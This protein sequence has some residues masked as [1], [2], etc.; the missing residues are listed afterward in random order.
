MATPLVV[1]V[2]P[3]GSGK[4]ALALQ[5]ATKFNGEIISAD[6]RTIYEGMDIGTAKPSKYDQAKV[7]H[8]L[9]S[10]LSPNEPFTAAE[11]QR[12]ASK[13]IDEITGR[14]K[15]PIIVGGTG[16]YIDGV[17]FDFAFLPPVPQAEREEL[18]RLSVKELQDKLT[19]EGIA[20]PDNKQNPRHLIR[21]LETNGA[22]P[23]KKNLR[24]NTLMLGIDISKEALLRRIEIRV[25]QMVK[26]GLKE[27]VY[28]LAEQYGWDAPGLSGVGYKEWHEFSSTNEVKAAIV[29]NTM[30]YAKRQ[31]TW[32][33][34]N[35]NINWV[36]NSAEA[37]KLVQ[38]FLQ[39]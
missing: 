8:Y 33:K 35:L 13:K 6:S 24:S 14:G 2:G 20:L 36:K 30:Q 19:L 31:R 17:V 23:V 7:P 29:R 26:A 21:S 12:L 11:F 25:E 3:T 28:K 16:L 37:E 10:F 18:Q 15:L 38:K 27:E 4:S 34:R 9:L 5:I 1:I 39:K 32:F 22:V